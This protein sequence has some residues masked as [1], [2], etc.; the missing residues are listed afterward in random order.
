MFLIFSF[1]FINSFILLTWYGSLGTGFYF[2]IASRGH[3]SEIVCSHWVF[4]FNVNSRER[5]HLT[6]SLFD[7]IFSSFCFA[8]CFFLLLLGEE[9]DWQKIHDAVSCISSFARFSLVSTRIFLHFFFHFPN[10]LHF[11]PSAW[12]VESTRWRSWNHFY[13]SIALENLDFKK[14]NC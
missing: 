7:V 3:F 10:S 12:K 9:Q 14:W 6:W 2:Q 8:C 1:P 4:A 13:I 11:K 5:S